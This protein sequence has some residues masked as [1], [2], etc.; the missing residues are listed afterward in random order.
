[1]HCFFLVNLGFCFSHLT[2]PCKPSP[3]PV[4]YC[5]KGSLTF[6]I[7]FEAD[8]SVPQIF[9]GLWHRLNNDNGW[10][11]FLTMTE[12]EWL[13]MTKTARVMTPCLDP[14]HD[15]FDS[16]RG[17]WSFKQSALNSPGLGIK[18]FLIR[19]FLNKGSIYFFHSARP[20]FLFCGL[21]NYG[22]ALLDFWKNR[23]K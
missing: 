16:I 19:R 15:I 7:I 6:A 9:E 22:S 13:N 1:M 20:D 11:V 12:I 2:D 8:L 4:A 5:G 17:V 3:S 18:W 10:D 14:G 21:L 23:K